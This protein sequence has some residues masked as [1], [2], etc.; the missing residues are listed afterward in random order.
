[1]KTAFRGSCLC[2]SVTFEGAA[3]PNFVSHC[4]CLD[5]RKTSGTGH[6][7]D[8]GVTLDEV[9]LEG[10]LNDF[11]DLADS[12]NTITRRF[13]PTCGSKITTTNSAYPNDIAINIAM[14]VTPDLFQ[15]NT[16]YYASA[17]IP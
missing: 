9:S 7:T 14:L 15:P 2:G 3:E 17:R 12:G 1:M 5:C 6:S 11:T 8:F 10:T 13:C 16:V 4:C